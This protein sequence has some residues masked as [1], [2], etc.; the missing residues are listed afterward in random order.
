MFRRVP[1]DL[2]SLRATFG[3][4]RI[5]PGTALLKEL[6]IITYQHRDKLELLAI[7]KVVT[8]AAEAVVSIF[9]Q[10]LRLDT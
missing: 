9:R 1:S 7:L 4:L 5:E 10:Q 2:H 3:N 8:S 6:E